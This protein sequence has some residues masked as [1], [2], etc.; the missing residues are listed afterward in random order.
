ML[1][2]RKRCLLA[3]RDTRKGGFDYI[4]PFVELLIG[5][6]ER[7][8]N[9]NHIV[10]RSSGDHDETV[11]VAILGDLFGFGVCWL[12]SLG[13]AHQFDGTHAAQTTN[14]ADQRPFFLPAASALFKTLADGC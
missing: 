6:D 4:Q 9:T 14:V 2:V 13:T 5:D 12:A 11:L 1:C 8:E 10:E 7:N 3:F